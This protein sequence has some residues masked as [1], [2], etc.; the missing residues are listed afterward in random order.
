M[1]SVR[2]LVVNVAA[3]VLRVPPKD[4]TD[5]TRLNVDQ[6]NTVGLNIVMQTGELLVIA[7][8]QGSTVGDLIA[9]AGGE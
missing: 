2:E 1:S 6:C 4:I 9:A 8:L 3:G 7:D 5:K